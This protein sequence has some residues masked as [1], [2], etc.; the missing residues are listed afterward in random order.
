M[1]NIILKQTACGNEDFLTLCGELDTFLN[2]AIGGEDRREK[3]KKFNHEDTMDYVLVAYDS[4]CPV[5]CGALRKYS[6]EEIEIKRVFV[7]DAYRGKNIGGAVLEGLI[8]QAQK[9][10][11]RKMI[12]ETGEFLERSVRLYERY[13]FE[14]IENYGAYAGME[15]SLCM[16]REV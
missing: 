7:R 11:F 16:G 12:L 2:I 9:M 6:D 8:A 4:G 10:G 5:G 14:K 13:G 3:Y 15:E 1:R